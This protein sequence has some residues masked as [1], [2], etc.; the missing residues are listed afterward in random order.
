MRPTRESNWRRCWNGSNLRTEYIRLTLK[1]PL[2]A[3]THGNA[4][5]TLTHELPL[6]IRR[7]GVEK[8]LLLAGGAVVRRQVDRAL[9]KAVARAHCWLDDFLSGRLPSLTAIA[10]REKVTKRYV[11]RLIRLGL[12]A[13]EMVDEIAEGSQALELTTQALLTRKTELPLSWQA[14][15]KE[16][17][18]ALPS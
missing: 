6:Q 1:L 7:R 8:R 12:L 2:P 18:Q 17:G 13:P 5:L 11:S 16:F 10:A 4:T 3:A 9:L 15:K 14:Q